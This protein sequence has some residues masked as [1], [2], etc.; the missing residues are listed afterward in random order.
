MSENGIWEKQRRIRNI[1]ALTSTSGAA[2]GGHPK[3]GYFS[4]YHME[5]LS[6][7]PEGEYLTDRI[8]AEASALIRSRDRQRPFFLN[9]WHYAVH[10]PLQAKAE[11]I[12]YFEEKAKRWDWTSRIRLRS[13]IRFRSCRKKISELP[14]GS[15]SQ[16]QCMPR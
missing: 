2:G 11:D 13:A 7:G 16:I 4:P 3:K 8:G 1:M 14:A 10:T 6:D 9:L 15:F 5:N 12:A